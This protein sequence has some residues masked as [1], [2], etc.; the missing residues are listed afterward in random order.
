MPTKEDIAMLK[1]RKRIKEALDSF[2]LN[3]AEDLLSE[4]TAAQESGYSLSVQE[5]NLLDRL[6]KCVSSYRNTLERL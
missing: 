2:D 5:V 3:D 6:I 4:I 1:F